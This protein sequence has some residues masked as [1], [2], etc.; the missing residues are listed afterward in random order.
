MDLRG[1]QRF[2]RPR[3]CVLMLLL[4]ACLPGMAQRVEEARRLIRQGAAEQAIVLLDPEIAAREQDG[5]TSGIVRALVVRARAAYDLGRSPAA[6][7][8]LQ[9]CIAWGGAVGAW[10]EVGDAWTLK[11][12][13][14]QENSGMDSARSAYERAIAAHLKAGDTS[15]C[16]LVYDNMGQF[17]LNNGDIRGAMAW[18]EKALACLKD[19]AWP[20]HYR[21][22]ALIESSLCNYHTWSGQ[23][24]QGVQHGER[25]VELA[26][27]SGEVYAIVHTGTQLAG[28]Y[29]AIGK[30]SPALKLLLRS[31]S[32]ARAHAFPAI[33]H[34]D[35][36]ELLSS[37]YEALG[38][39]ARALYYYRQRA[40]YND[41]ARSLS[42][43]RTIE[44]MERR[45]LLVA[46]SLRYQGRLRE[47]AAR[48]LAAIA[49]QRWIT[50]GALAVGVLVLVIAL[51][52]RDRDRRT[53]RANALILQQQERLVRSERARQAEE[54]RTRIARDIHDEIGGEL[55][56]IT[57]LGSKARREWSEGS[58]GIEGSLDRIRDLSRRVGAALSDIVWA[59]DPDRDTVQGLVE[60]ARGMVETLLEDAPVLADIRFAHQDGDRSIDP[61]VRRDI[62]M[63]LKEALNNTLKHAKATRVQVLFETDALT[64]HLQVRDDGLGFAEGTSRGN[65]LRNIRARVERLHARFELSSAPGAGTTLELR[66]TF[67]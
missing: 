55:T 43:R 66:G 45:Q 15:A 64:Y 48:H 16:A 62:F 46:D 33:K 17:N 3:G 10:N 21:T 22:A 36:A 59:V 6:L 67:R 56:K 42:T 24:E 38:D 27:R 35:I 65:V 53:K 41:S 49:T 37:A 4:C 50:A 47:Q 63:V 58:P 39:P 25:S 54:L 61:A 23:G 9:R 26:G 1:M 5:D 2:I 20:D 18:S 13:I 14:A 52:Y 28:A 19:T 34:R 12:V 29:L 51:L 32:L 31:D 7:Y 11:G 30:V 8:D 57:L 40:A 60:H 44:A